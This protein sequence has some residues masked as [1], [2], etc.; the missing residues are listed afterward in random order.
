[1]DNGLWWWQGT[2]VPSGTRAGSSAA[3]RHG[4]REREPCPAAA[5]ERAQAATGRARMQEVRQGL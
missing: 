5:A 3:A 2:L 4:Q 1:M